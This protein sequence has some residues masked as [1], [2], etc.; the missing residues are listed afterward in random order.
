VISR[1][2]LELD[3]FTREIARRWASLG[4]SAAAVH[5][6]VVRS[7]WGTSGL[8]AVSAVVNS[9]F[10]LVKRTAERGA[11]TIAWLATTTP[12]SLRLPAGRTP[13]LNTYP[14]FAT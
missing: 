12:G 8:S 5:P 14:A 13:P 3:L 6:G 11:D 10:R 1:L 9:P 7:Q 2:R 4:I